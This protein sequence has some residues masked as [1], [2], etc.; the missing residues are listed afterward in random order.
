MASD[1]RGQ[2][3]LLAGILLV[4]MF[5]LFSTQVALIANLGQQAGRETANPLLND[6]LGLRRSLQAAFTQELERD[7]GTSQCLSMDALAQRLG[8]RLIQLE[9]MSSNRGHVL[10]FANATINVPVAADRTIYFN[11]TASMTDGI[12]TLED[13]LRY[14]QT[15]IGTIH[16]PSPQQRCLPR[17]PD[18]WYR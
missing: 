6:Y 10:G 9:D 14:V 15:C 4:L 2:V 18:C 1:E 3:I 16:G 5:I 13:H 12:T 8:G 11:L 17:V 7:L